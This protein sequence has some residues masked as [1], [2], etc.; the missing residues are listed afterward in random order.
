MNKEAQSYIDQAATAAI[1][2]ALA[3]GIVRPKGNYYKQTEAR[4]YAFPTLQK[5]IERYRLDIEDL[6][7]E[8]ITA[9]SKDITSYGGDGIRL[10]PEERQEG[11]ILAVELKLQRDQKAVEEINQALETVAADEYYKIIEMRYFLNCD[12][13]YVAEM[14]HCAERTVRYNRSRLINKLSVF[15]YG[16]SVLE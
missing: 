6:K 9:K 14:L 4:L 11:K 5:N 8:K 10:T 13:A 16:A 1:K 2:K 12:D 7:R 15:L 3:A